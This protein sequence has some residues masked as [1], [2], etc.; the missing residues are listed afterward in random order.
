MTSE[1]PEVQ[2][3]TD[4]LRAEHIAKRFGAVTALTDV[5][6][7]LVR[8]EVLGLIGDNGAGKSTL[9]KIICGFHQPDAG[10]IL[11]DRQQVRL[12]SVDHARSLGIDVVY[13]DLALV[14][15]LSVYHNMFLNRERVR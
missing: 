12:R 6:L 5:N 13:Q 3:A 7:H 8:G 9:V 14:N 1:A 10:R 15:Q 2:A 11:V 4:V